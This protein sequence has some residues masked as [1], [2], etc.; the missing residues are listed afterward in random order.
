MP[1]FVGFPDA[2]MHK[3]AG[4]SAVPVEQVM[5]VTLAC[6]E[7]IKLAK[8]LERR[9]TGTGSSLDVDPETYLENRID[10]SDEPEHDTP[11]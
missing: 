10:Y 9:Q 2:E 5:A 3:P 8:K 1:D 11:S 4:V 6:H 7:Q